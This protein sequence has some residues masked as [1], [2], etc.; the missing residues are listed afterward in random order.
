MGP[1]PLPGVVDDPGHTAH[2]VRAPALALA[3]WPSGLD[4]AA[5]GLGTKDR[6]LRFAPP[7]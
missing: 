6:G 7:T 2:G 1:C 5:D 4:A 3:L